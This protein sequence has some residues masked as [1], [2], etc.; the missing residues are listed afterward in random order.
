M[1]WFAGI[2]N[3][4][5]VFLCSIIGLNSHFITDC[6]ACRAVMSNSHV[7]RILLLELISMILKYRNFSA[8]WINFLFDLNL[9]KI[10]KYKSS[11]IFC[12]SS[13]LNKTALNVHFFKKKRFLHIFGL[14]AIAFH[15]II[16]NYLYNA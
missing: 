8:L 14:K 13:C 16:T 15:C 9:H 1:W 7:E 2:K 11:D 10:T 12:I 4:F 3:C 5:N 6:C